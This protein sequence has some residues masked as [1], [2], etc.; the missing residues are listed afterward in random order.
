[1]PRMSQVQPKTNIPVDGEK[2]KALRGK[3]TQREIEEKAGLPYGRLTQY[4]NGR[5]DVPPDHLEKLLTFY[6]VK[7]PEVMT[8]EGLAQVASTANQVARLLGVP[9]PVTSSP[10]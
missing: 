9:P 2:L 5:S 10:A 1:M 7:G 8:E 6:Q 4:E 3:A